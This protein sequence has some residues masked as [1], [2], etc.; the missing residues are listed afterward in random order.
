[1]SI[2]KAAGVTRGCA[3]DVTVTHIDGRRITYGVPTQYDARRLGRYIVRKNPG[4]EVLCTTR[5][6]VFATWRADRPL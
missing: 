3:Y 4:A 2:Y 5:Y 1:M 6:L